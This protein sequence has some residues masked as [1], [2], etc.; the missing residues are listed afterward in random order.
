MRGGCL[1]QAKGR[2]CGIFEKDQSNLNQLGKMKSGQLI[3]PGDRKRSYCVL[4]LLFTICSVGGSG[5]RLLVLIP[6]VIMWAT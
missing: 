2:S 3:T 5:A 4:A 1:L 6:A